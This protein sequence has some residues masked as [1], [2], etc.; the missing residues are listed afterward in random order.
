MAHIITDLEIKSFVR[1]VQNQLVSLK[2]EDLRELTENLE[3]DLL[4]RRDAEGNNFKLG[5]AREYAK[6]LAEA[7]GLD[8]NN[9]EV[10][11]MNI[12]FLKV[13]KALLSYFRTLSPAWAI[14]RGWL[15]FALIYTPLVYGRIGEIPS[16]T[17]DTL[18]LIALV[19]VNI[20]LGRKQFA[21]LKYPL[22]ALNVLLLAGTP[23]VVAD[24]AGAFDLYKKYVI[25]EST[26]QLVFQGN[27]VRA[28]CAIGDDGSKIYNVRKLTNETGYPI[29]VSEMN[30][31]QS[32]PLC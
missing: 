31:V 13:W 30:P 9:I 27:P 20:W 7:A 25:F 24:V 10:S 29:F 16:N 18:V 6:D 11:R 23:V 17:R 19:V 21:S 12:E 2:A 3:A 1:K 28:V 5:D 22:I 4:D 32:V 14:V 8:L 15:M 26:S